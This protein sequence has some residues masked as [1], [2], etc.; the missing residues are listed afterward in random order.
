MTP[1]ESRTA[2]FAER[3]IK[4]LAKRGI[5]AYFCTSAAE[6]I[7]KVRSLMNDGDVVTWGGSATIR[8]LG[9]TR[10]LS[11]AGVYRVLDRDLAPTP[12]AAQDIYRQAFSAD[13]YLTSFNAMS[14]DGVIVNIDATGNRV[15]AI[16][17]GPR[18]VILVG[19]LGKVCATTEAALARARSTAA[20]TNV[21][22]FDRKTP[23]RIDGVCHNCVSPDSI[24]N[25]VHF[26]RHSPQHRHTVVLLADDFGY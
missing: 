25:Y 23:C 12:E 8:D 7:E 21:Q 18:R 6:A 4:N 17:F 19:S 11:D 13:V 14:E 22:R 3:V 5:D 2:L 24:C 1:K 26:L 15:A 20:P 9:L 16:T 10:A